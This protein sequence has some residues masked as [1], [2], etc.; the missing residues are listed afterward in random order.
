[1]NKLFKIFTASVML[2]AMLVISGCGGGD[3]FAGNWV[4][5]EKNM[6]V[7]FGGNYYKQLK[8]EQN[9]DAYL[10]TETHNQYKLQKTKNGGRG[11]MSTY[12]GTFVW[13]TD[14]PEKYSAKANGENTL[15]I[16]GSMGMMTVTY[17]EKDGTLLIGKQVYTKEKDG[18]MQ[19]FK[20]AEQKRL[21]ALYDANDMGFYDKKFL[22]SLNFADAAADKK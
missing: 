8:I 21:Q 13:K 6:G 17:V 10:L 20:E 14:A 11:L 15:V 9:G 7:E 12:D 5:Q 4:T 22:T 3:K 19:K 16:N 18:D 1:M 2:V